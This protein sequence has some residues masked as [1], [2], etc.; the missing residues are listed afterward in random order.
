LFDEYSF[1]DFYNS[2]W[3]LPS[4]SYFFYEDWERV[5]FEIT[6]SCCRMNSLFITMKAQL[7]YSII[8]F[9]QFFR[10]ILLVS[11]PLTEAI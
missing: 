7:G 6:P 3:F 4:H 8:V 5:D 10:R 1:Y 2:L 11:F 9:H